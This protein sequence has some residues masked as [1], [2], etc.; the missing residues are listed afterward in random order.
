MSSSNTIPV[1]YALKAAKWI[2]RLAYTIAIIGTCGSYGTQVA[3]LL[4]HQVGWFSYIIPSTIDMLAIC[5]MLARQLPELDRGSRRIA[6]FIL[7]VAVLVSIAANVTG[8][9]NLIARL[10]HAWPIAAYLLGEILANRVRMYAAR[11]RHERNASM[12]AD[13]AAKMQVNASMAAAQA[14]IA[15]LTEALTKPA[16][17]GGRKRIGTKVGANG[18]VRRTD[19]KPVSDRTAARRRG[20]VRERIAEGEPLADI[21]E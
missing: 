3:L 1:E 19:G 6:S 5:A 12:A 21:I 8:G 15:E 4:V 17:R 14:R 18:A 2:N 13:E 16:S 20:E 11:L 9:H 10:A 7:T